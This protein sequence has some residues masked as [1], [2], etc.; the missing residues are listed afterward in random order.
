VPAECAASIPASLLSPLLTWE[1][2][3]ECRGSSPPSPIPKASVDSLIF[4]PIFLFC[5][6]FF[7]VL[8]LELRA[9]TLSNSTSPVFLKD[10]SR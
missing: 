7:V 2:E 8:G 9:F 5:F 10:F 3:R 1:L 4:P 6:C